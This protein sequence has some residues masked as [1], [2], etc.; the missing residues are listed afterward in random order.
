MSGRAARRAGAVRG[1]R[2]RRRRR[3]PTW[4]ASTFAYQ[5]ESAVSSS[6]CIETTS[7]VRLRQHSNAVKPLAALRSTSR[8]S[9]RKALSYS[10]PNIMY[11]SASESALCCSRYWNESSRPIVSPS[12]VRA[13]SVSYTSRV[14]F[15]KV[16]KTVVGPTKKR[17]LLYS[18]VRSMVHHSESYARPYV[19]A[20]SVRNEAAIRMT[21]TATAARAKPEPQ[22]A[23]KERPFLRA[24]ARTWSC[25]L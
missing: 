14:A 3:R 7:A 18:V 23:V 24:I 5:R 4:N 17:P 20:S 10:R 6:A 13:G 16:R 9:R 12:R 2:R 19:V 15:G 1:D 22:Q 25:G 21:A 11:S 8:A